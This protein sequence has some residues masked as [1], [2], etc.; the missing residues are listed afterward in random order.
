LIKRIE[1]GTVSCSAKIY[2]AALA[3][4]DRYK[5][6]ITTTP[7]DPASWKTVLDYGVLNK[8][9]I[10]DLI[11]GQ[12]IFIRVSGGNSLGWGIPSEQTAFIPR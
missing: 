2:V 9:E 10:R 12:E 4:A 8:M 1:D 6:E 3:D 7:A 5:V 11:R